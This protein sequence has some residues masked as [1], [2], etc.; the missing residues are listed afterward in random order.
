MT[1]CQMSKYR[2]PRRIVGEALLPT[3]IATI[4]SLILAPAQRQ[5]YDNQEFLIVMSGFVPDEV[6]A[7]RDGR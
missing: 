1:L 6:I 5:I 3:A 2:G 7:A 4:T